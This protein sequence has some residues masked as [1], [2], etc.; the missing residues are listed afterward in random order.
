MHH[1]ARGNDSVE[2]V[3]LN[4]AGMFAAV[5]AIVPTSRGNDFEQAV[6]A[7]KKDPMT[8]QDCPSVSTLEAATKA[9]VENNMWALLAVAVLGVL[10]SFFIARRL[11]RADPDYKEPRWGFWVAGPILV[12]AAATFIW[13][14]EWFIDH[15]HYIAAVGLFVCI[16]IVAVANATRGEEK[17]VPASLK[18]ANRY[19]WIAWTMVLVAAVGAGLLAFDQIS[20]FLLEI[21]IA[22]LFAVF[23]AVQT[24]ERLPAAARRKTANGST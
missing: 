19:A 2:D 14:T 1:R 3:F 5:V 24:F 7:C 4:I 11:R 10:A 8:D 9:N 23:W 6:E 18:V 12:A 13:A 15:A 17:K 21:V 20:L 16:L 22:L